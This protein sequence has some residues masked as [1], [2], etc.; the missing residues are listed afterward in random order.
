MMLLTYRNDHLFA[1]TEQGEFIG[2]IINS[3]NGKLEKFPV[4]EDQGTF[5][6]LFGGHGY[7]YH[8]NSNAHPFEI[9]YW[10]K[11]FKNPELLPEGTRSVFIDHSNDCR[12]DFEA[13]LADG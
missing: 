5:N 3:S 10:G 7:I 6:F 12:F 4:E 2:K 11:I 9:E 13:V 1:T 8:Q